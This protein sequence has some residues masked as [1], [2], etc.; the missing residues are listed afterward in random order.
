MEPR[1]ASS[2]LAS[3]RVVTVCW[4]TLACRVALSS[5]TPWPAHPSQRHTDKRL[6]V[7]SM[8]G[9][10]HCDIAAAP[11]CT[12]EHTRST[13]ALSRHLPLSLLE[14]ACVASTQYMAIKGGHLCISSTPRAVSASGKPSPPHPPLFSVASSVPSHFSP[15]LSPYAGPGASLSF[16][17]AFWT[18]KATPSPSSTAP[19]SNAPPTPA[20]L[21]SSY[22]SQSCQ[23]SAPWAREACGIHLAEGWP[24]ASRHELCHGTRSEHASAERTAPCADAGHVLRPARPCGP[25]LPQPILALWPDRSRPSTR[26]ARGSS[27]VSVQKPFKN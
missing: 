16:R 21:A 14:Q 19:V 9:C 22:G 26:C 11:C 10:C 8:Q 12:R 6:R 1:L 18:K 25:C 3:R 4:R 23:A 2:Y 5:A 17:A 24:V 20:F 27:S 7:A 15:P 13:A